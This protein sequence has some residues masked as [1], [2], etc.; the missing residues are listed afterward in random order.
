M[1]WETVFA[2]ENK[3]VKYEITWNDTCGVHVYTEETNTTPTP[4]PRQHKS[5]PLNPPQQNKSRPSN[6]ASQRRTTGTRRK[7]RPRLY[8]TVASFSQQS[9]S[10]PQNLTPRST[11]GNSNALDIETTSLDPDTSGP[12]RF[13]FPRPL[14][15]D[16][17]SQKSLC[18]PSN[19]SSNLTSKTLP[20]LTKISLRTILADEED[21]EDD[22][23][24]ESKPLLSQQ[25]RPITKTTV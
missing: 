15:S 7:T 4:T 25:P 9:S 23:K 2:R 18:S 13:A 3:K 14:Y 1:V 5:Q 10:T 17:S 16:G 12:S 20:S 19:L 24:S 22:D 11:T 8:S 6:K 21:D